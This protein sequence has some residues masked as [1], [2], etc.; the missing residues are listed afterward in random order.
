MPETP[1]EAPIYSIDVFNNPVGCRGL[2]SGTSL[3]ALINRVNQQ[4]LAIRLTHL[5]QIIKREKTASWLFQYAL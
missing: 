1:K 4:F 5:R 2:Q 3:D